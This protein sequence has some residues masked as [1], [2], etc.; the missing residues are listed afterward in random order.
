MMITKS[1]KRAN[2]EKER[3]AREEKK[4][5]KAISQVKCCP[6]CGSRKVYVWIGDSI[7]PFALL[8]CA[9]HAKCKKCGAEWV[10]D[11]WQERLCET[12]I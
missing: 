10:S 5:D 2:R 11:S 12:P 3:T 7:N 9:L 6:E 8:S 4:R 1:R